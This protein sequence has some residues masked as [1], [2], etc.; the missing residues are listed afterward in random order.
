MDGW[1]E[2][3]TP[4]RA[5]VLLPLQEPAA[6]IYNIPTACQKQTDRQARL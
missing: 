4:D 6:H 1:M 5:K 3:R 2:D